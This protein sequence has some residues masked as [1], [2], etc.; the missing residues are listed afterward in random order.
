MLWKKSWWQT[1]WLF[2]ICLAALFLLHSLTIDASDYEVSSWSESLQRNASL[3]EGERQILGNYQ[4]RIWSLWFRLLF[5]FIWA[6]IAIILGAFCLMT[7]CPRVPFYG[8]GLF[9]FS[10]PVSRRKVLLLQ[11]AVG[12]SEMFLIALIPS[13]FLPIIARFHGQWFSWSDI[14]VYV[15]LT[16]F[17]GAVFFFGAFLLT[18]ILNNWFIAFVLLETIVIALF[19]PFI[20]FEKRPWWNI[21]GV[22]AG[23][24]YFYHGQIPWLAL[25]ISLILSVIFLFTAVLIYERRDL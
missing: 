6:D 22:M 12:Y 10:L 20:N 15:L 13:L 9:T 11:A 4:G 17:G 3:S 14:L 25:S 24:S 5:N 21:L 23:E 2:F 8:A 16:I 19:L 7:V 1:R 18:V